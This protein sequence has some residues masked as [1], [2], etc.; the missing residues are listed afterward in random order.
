VADSN[1]V[2]ETSRAP[3]SVPPAEACGWEQL[4]RPVWLFDPHALRGVYANAAAL[5]LWDAESLD[6]LLSRDFQGLSPAV[7]ARTAMLASRTARGE[8]VQERWTF[9]PRGVPTTVQASI[10]AFELRPGYRVLLFEASPVDVEEG[11]RRAVEAL[12][13]TSTVISLFDTSGRLIFSNPAGYRIYGPDAPDFLG[14]FHDVMEGTGLLAVAGAGE[15]TT[16]LVQVRTTAGLRWHHV[17]ARPTL[18]PVTGQQGLL[19][20]EQ[21]VTA[22]IEAERGLREAD[23]RAAVAE[24]RQ[25]FL[26]NM[27]HELRTPLNAI[28]GQAALLR[29]R[30]DGDDVAI[31]SDAARTLL[32]SVNDMI[33]LSELDLGRVRLA[34]I[35]FCPQ[36]C[37]EAVSSG[38]VVESDWRAGER[39]QGD[40]ERTGLIVR[41]FVS[42]AIKF[43]GREGASI[44]L[45]HERDAEGRVWLSITVQDRGPGIDN[46]RISAL[47]ERFSQGDSSTTKSFGGGGLGLAVS[48]ELAALMGGRVE[49]HNRDGGGAVFRLVAPFAPAASVEAPLSGAEQARTDVAGTV[50]LI[51]DDAV[52]HP[53]GFKVLYADDHEVNRKIVTAMLASRGIV[54]ETVENGALAVEAVER[55]HYGLVLMDIQMP[56]MDGVEATRAIRRLAGACATVPI[57]ALT[58]NTLDDQ[59]A[60]YAS[61]G[62]Q[63]CLAKPVDMAALFS[64]VDHWSGAIC[65]TNP[66]AA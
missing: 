46:A 56:V 37:V 52:D 11:E 1:L 2:P 40:A 20:N 54:C 27:S 32:D 14:R 47:F 59:R 42:N 30:V 35:P 63:A 53:A 5:A 25:R 58:A 48:N 21:D 16:A 55:G 41:H 60:K 49:A 6:E 28:I 23:H 43:A 4:S 26:A 12:R 17:D 50:A 45:G 39:L 7:Q 51:A 44:R 61:V 22:Q 31:I 57:L 34:Q 9:Y 13:H 15:T 66:Q 3:V 29:G 64:A 19:L 18:D 38:L 62:M 24:S 8:V 33:L 10:S 36:T 65:D